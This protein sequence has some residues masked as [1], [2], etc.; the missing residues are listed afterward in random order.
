M[1]FIFIWDIA[2]FFIYPVFFYITVKFGKFIF[3]ISLGVYFLFAYVCRIILGIIFLTGDMNERE[4]IEKTYSK[5]D[6]YDCENNK[7]SIIY[8]M[9]PTIFHDGKQFILKQ[10]KKKSYFVFCSRL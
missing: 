9:F 5:L 2:L 6:D 1:R 10:L 8:C 3:Y 7:E 4:K